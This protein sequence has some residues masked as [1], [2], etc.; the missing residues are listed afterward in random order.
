MRIQADMDGKTIQDRSVEKR[1]S[2]GPLFAAPPFVQLH[3]F[4]ALAAF[5]LGAIQLALPKGVLLHRIVGYSWVALMLAIAASSFTIQGI[6]Q[7]GPFSMIHLLSTTV[8]ILTPL[9]VLAARR[10][11]VRRH[12][13]AMIT[14]FAGAL[15]VAGLFTLAPGRIMHDVVFGG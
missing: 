4:A 2:L 15:V 10:H 12:S 14:L 3:A 5:A 13:I 7:W 9:A 11:H 1:M 6:R 8:L